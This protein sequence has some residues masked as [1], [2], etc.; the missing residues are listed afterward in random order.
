[1]VENQEPGGESDIKLREW[2][3]GTKLGRRVYIRMCSIDNLYSKK[4]ESWRARRGVSLCTI[5]K[6]LLVHRGATYC[7]CVPI[8]DI[9]V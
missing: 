4:G 8:Q 3:D 6:G 9:Y 7:R 2:G 1:M 5:C